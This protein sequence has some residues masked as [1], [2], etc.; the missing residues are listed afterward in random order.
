VLNATDE[1]VR[2]LASARMPAEAGRR[3]VLRFRLISPVRRLA[4]IGHELRLRKARFPFLAATRLL[5]LRRRPAHRLGKTIGP[6]HR[7]VLRAARRRLAAGNGRQARMGQPARPH[8][9]P[10][11][12]AQRSPHAPPGC[13]WLRTG[14]DCFISARSSRHC[15]G[16]INKRAN[17]GCPAAPG[18]FQRTASSERGR[19]RPLMQGRMPEPC[20]GRARNR[21]SG[22]VDPEKPPSASE[23]RRA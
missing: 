5:T 7:P 17:P 15:A 14:L 21:E 1:A 13:S 18:G 9:R 8:S 10:R 22:R 12:A 20:D 6:L 3:G 4:F 11:R 16:R 19:L 23:P 2:S